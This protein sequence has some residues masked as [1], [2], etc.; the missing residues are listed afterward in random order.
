MEPL[1]LGT[2]GLGRKREARAQSEQEQMPKRADCTR[3]QA[4]GNPGVTFNREGATATF[5]PLTTPGTAT[6]IWPRISLAT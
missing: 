2:S 1:P 3:H 6:K 4:A 5:R